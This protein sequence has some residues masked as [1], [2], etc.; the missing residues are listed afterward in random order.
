MKIEQS[1]AGRLNRRQ[2]IIG[3]G[4][5]AMLI[6]ARFSMP[7]SLLHAGSSAGPIPFPPLPYAEDALAPCISSRTMNF[8]YGKHHRGYVEKTNDM[9]RNTR[10]QGLSLEE[11]MKRTAGVPDRS[12]IFNN[13]A[14]SWNHIFFWNSMKPGGGGAP[15]G[16]WKKEVESSFGG[17]ENFRR[18]FAESAASRFG[19]GYAW[20]VSDSGVLKI[21]ST[22][23]AGNP[24]TEGRVP[25]LN[26]DVWEHAYYLD[27]QNRR[28][29]YIS[30]F[31]DHLAN[32]D[33]AARNLSSAGRK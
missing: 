31:L 7:Q 30:A 24:L 5:A 14:Q 10:L 28:Q 23:N 29:D 4:A 1:E 2:F 27:Y 12:A 21:E 33:F 16:E 3:A 18:A 19:S 15:G 11:I 17:M 6:A 13:A 25:L 8:H 9:I 20:L 32:W 26:L 22:P